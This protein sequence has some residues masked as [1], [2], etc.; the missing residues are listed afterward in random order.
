MIT[1]AGAFCLHPIILSVLTS[2]DLGSKVRSNTSTEVT[3]EEDGFGY[4]CHIPIT[5][6]D[7]GWLEKQSKAAGIARRK[8]RTR[9]RRIED[10]QSFFVFSGREESGEVKGK[11]ERFCGGVDLE[12]C[13]R[14]N[15]SGANSTQPC[16]AP[17]CL[18]TLGSRMRVVPHSMVVHVCVC[19]W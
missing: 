19:S 12:H 5:T 14:T 10:T 17:G 11:G 4:L 8:K 16:N 1:Q 15:S 6:W 9:S 2:P 18:R 7:Q 3:C 13:D